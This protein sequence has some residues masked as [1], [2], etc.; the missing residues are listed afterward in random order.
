MSTQARFISKNILSGD[1]ISRAQPYDLLRNEQR[2]N[3][4]T[5]SFSGIRR[6]VCDQLQRYLTGIFNDQPDDVSWSDVSINQPQDHLFDT[7]YSF[8]QRVSLPHCTDAA[9][10][11]IDA[12]TLHSL[13]VLF[14][15]GTLKEPAQLITLNQL[16]DTEVRLANLLATEQIHAVQSAQNEEYAEPIT[17]EVIT[18]D[19][20]P[21]SGEWFSVTTTLRYNGHDFCWHMWWPINKT[22]EQTVPLAD[23]S[24]LQQLLAGV[25]LQLRIVLAKQKIPLNKIA[26]LAVGDILPIELNEPTPAYLGE[27]HYADGR[28]A[29]QRA[30]LVFQISHVIPL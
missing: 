1:T 27:Q 26:S 17:C 23:T 10:L 4:A 14:L 5:F 16:T 24:K 21:Q 3:A 18:T 30:S 9:Y 15:G 28:V 6:S 2:H 19:Q 8:W 25:P 7:D 20:L 29:E 12:A 11:L 22:E 13:S